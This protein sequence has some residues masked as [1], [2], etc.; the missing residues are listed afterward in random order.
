MHFPR[1]QVQS[2]P[3]LDVSCQTSNFAATIHVRTDL[4]YWA[5][6]AA[7]KL[8]KKKKERQTYEC[9][10]G[11]AILVVSNNEG[12]STT[13]ARWYILFFMY[14]G[15]LKQYYSQVPAYVPYKQV[16]WELFWRYNELGP[17]DLAPLKLVLRNPEAQSMVPVIAR[18]E[19][20]E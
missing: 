15:F 20:G 12:I 10:P 18:T 1:V 3:P 11:N 17:H 19:R 5:L 6:T 4:W 16:T 8:K 2:D 7:P 13:S 9:I 14:L